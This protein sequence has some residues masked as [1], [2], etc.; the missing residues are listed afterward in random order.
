MHSALWVALTACATP[1]NQALPAK[2]L[3]GESCSHELRCVL[4]LLQEALLY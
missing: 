1:E 2:G 4:N 3:P